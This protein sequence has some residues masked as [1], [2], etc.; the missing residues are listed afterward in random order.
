MTPLPVFEP[1]QL[2]E[3]IGQPVRMIEF[4]QNPWASMASAT[5]VKPA[6]LA[7]MT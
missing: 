4:R 7:P 2:A 6:I 5:F 3:A 1:M